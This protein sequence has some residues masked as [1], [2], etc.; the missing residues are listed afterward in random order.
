VN[1][2]EENYEDVANE[3]NIMI[4]RC[5]SKG[6]TRCL[7]D[8][9]LNYIRTQNSLQDFK[10][11]CYWTSAHFQID[12]MI[13][14]PIG[15]PLTCPLCHF[16]L[17]SQMLCFK[18]EISFIHVVYTLFGL[19]VPFQASSACISPYHIKGPVRSLCF[20]WLL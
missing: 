9:T 5:V 4:I 2:Y 16:S 12:H 1:Q 20:S 10:P 3:N 6:N 8:I 15:S 13:N 18:H 7:A 14:Q 11:R 19:P 17:L